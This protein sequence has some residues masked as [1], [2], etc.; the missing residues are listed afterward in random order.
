[1]I[2][3]LV[4]ILTPEDGTNALYRNVDNKPTNDAAQNP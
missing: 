4:D 2:K 3:T 1:M